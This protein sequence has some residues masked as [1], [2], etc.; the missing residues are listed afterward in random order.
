MRA[1]LRLV[2]YLARSY[3]GRGLDLQDLIEEGNVGLL[4]AA[5]NFDPDMDTR[6]STYAKFW[7]KQSM[8]RAVLSSTGPVRMPFYVFDLLTKWHRRTAQLREELGRMPSRE[9]VARDLHLSRKKLAVIDR[10]LHLRD[11]ASH[12][13]ASDDTAAPSAAD[14]KR[15]S[16]LDELPQ[17]LR[18][19]DARKAE[20]LRLRFGLDGGGGAPSRKL[21]TSSA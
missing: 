4:H 18:R 6:F 14:S 17:H 9:E 16:C 1:N 21:A 11:A 12:V 15:H 2:V 13:T 20:V 10:A 7:I 8:Y 5:E 3:R 19:M